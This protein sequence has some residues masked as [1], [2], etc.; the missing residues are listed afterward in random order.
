MQDV[1]GLLRELVTRKGSDL[2]LSE[3]LRPRLRVYGDLIDLEDYPV[4]TR[5]MLYELMRALLDPK[6]FKEFLAQGDIDFAWE[7]E[8]VARYRCNYFV[9]QSGLG[10][11]FR[12]VPDTVVPF[13]RLRMP[14]AVIR[15]TQQRSGLILLT[16][17]TGSG[18][19][20]TM[21]AMLDQINSMRVCHIITIEDPIEFVHKR[22]KAFIVQREIGGHTR[23]FG[24]A[25]R[26]ALREDPD[27]LMVGELREAESAALSLTAAE[28][29]FLVLATLHTGSAANSINRILSMF[30][31]NRRSVIRQQFANT[32]LGVVSQK[33]LRRRDGQGRVPGAEVLVA[34]P[35][36]RNIIREGAV[37]QIPSVFQQGASVG[38]QT[39]DQSI[40]TLLKN[41][42]IDK[43]E[44]GLYMN[45]KNALNMVA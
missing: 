6:R 15:F 38:C 37:H 44:A 7:W 22:K 9:S 1:Y 36:L 43:R 26:A 42:L 18:K 25:L 41:G 3:G 34:T 32:L 45:D 8:G 27:I 11:V 12:L 35:Q 29:G 19:S 21:A 40:L 24:S 13:S 39:M 23:S 17:P 20:T 2:H 4:L 30:P 31:A 10:A 28:M 14:Q 33:L 5:A 16:G